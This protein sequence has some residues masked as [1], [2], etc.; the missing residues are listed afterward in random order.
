MSSVAESLSAFVVQLPRRHRGCR[1]QVVSIQHSTLLSAGTDVVTTTFVQAFRQTL[2][3]VPAT[4]TT[5][6]NLETVHYFPLFVKSFVD[7]TLQCLGDD[8]VE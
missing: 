2:L 3:A 1:F 5:Y 4:I 7:K 6:C 8:T